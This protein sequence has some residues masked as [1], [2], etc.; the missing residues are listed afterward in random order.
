MHTWTEKDKTL[1]K[2]IHLTSENWTSLVLEWSIL[3]G[4]SH[5]NT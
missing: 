5:P 4:T 2:K 3:V 1:R